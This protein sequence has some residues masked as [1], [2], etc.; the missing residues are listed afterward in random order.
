MQT[1]TRTE[2]YQDS[3]KA[4]FQL[5][6]WTFAWGATLALAKFGPESLWD[7]DTMSW[8][9]VALNVGIGIGWIVAHARYLRAIDELQRKIMQDALAITLGVTWVAGFA[10]IV[11]DSADLISYNADAGSL[12]ILMSVIYVVAT[13]AGHLRYR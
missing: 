7:S 4:T 8:A 2:G 5:F 6:L 3:I 13:A 9:A 11:A 10:Y 12:A 1:Q